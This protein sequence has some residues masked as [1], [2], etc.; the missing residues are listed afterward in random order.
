MWPLEDQ[1]LNSAD[2]RPGKHA[3]PL[4]IT[5]YEVWWWNWGLETCRSSS[6]IHFHSWVLAWI[7]LEFWPKSIIQSL[8]LHLLHSM[9][10]NI[11]EKCKVMWRNCKFWLREIF[12]CEMKTRSK[13]GESPK[14][15]YDYQYILCPN[16][17]LIKI[18]HG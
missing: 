16:L 5:C 12:W 11:K 18:N 17:I 13:N 6:P 10:Q 8:I 1:F 2:S 3:N 9:I 7:R 4:Q 15:C 14:F